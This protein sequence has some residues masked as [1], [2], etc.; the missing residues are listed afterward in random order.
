[1]RKLKN[2]RIDE[3]S[4]VLRGAGEGCMVM[5]SKADDT[6]P[7]VVFAADALVDSVQ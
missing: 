6:N 3:V 1:M 7:D 5:F 2:L 4:S